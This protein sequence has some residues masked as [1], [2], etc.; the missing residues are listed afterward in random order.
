MPYM[1]VVHRYL[2]ASGR[3]LDQLG[4]KG[5]CH[6]WLRL[7]F[8]ERPGNLH[9]GPKIGTK[10]VLTDRAISPALPACF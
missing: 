7:A 3:F 8:H 4:L 10:S 2:R 5:T 6:A 1:R 9:W